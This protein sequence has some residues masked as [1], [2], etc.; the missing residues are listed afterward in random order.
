M[1]TTKHEYYF[2]ICDGI[3]YQCK[4]YSRQIGAV[5]VIDEAVIPGRN[6]PPR[7]VPHCDHFRRIECEDI[8]DWL[9][10][11]KEKHSMMGITREETIILDNTKTCPRQ[12]MDFPSGQG[13]IFCT[14]AH[15]EEN[16]IINCA[17][18]GIKTK[19]AHLYLNDSIPCP[20]CASAIINAGITHVFY[21]LN[22]SPYA[23]QDL[24]R[25][26]F[27]EARVK[28]EGIQRGV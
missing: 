8:S 13:M 26:M 3:S 25:W 6:G 21:M 7:G 11:Q 22:K 27:V 18:M 16:V 17:R 12:V 5:L 20:R 4:C 23:G 10:K 1:T 9:D 14:A 2:S 19:G 24:S 28:I 15:A